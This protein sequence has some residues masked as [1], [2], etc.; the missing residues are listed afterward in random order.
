MKIAITILLALLVLCPARA[1]DNGRAF[2]YDLVQTGQAQILPAW[3][4]GMPSASPAIHA[5]ISFPIAPPSD[6]SDLAVTLCFTETTGGFLRV[7]WTGLQTS[8]ML[9]DNLFEGIAMPNQRTLLIKR[10]TLTSPGTITVQSSETTLNVSRIHFEWVDPGILSLAADAKQAGLINAT[11]TVLKDGDINGAPL[12][13]T[14]D[15]I[16]NSTVTAALNEKPERIEAGVEFVGALQ[17][18]P[19]HARLEVQISGAPVD[20]AVQLILNGALVGDIAMDIPDLNDPGYQATDGTTPAYTGWRKGVIFIP[21]EK[22]KVGD[23]QFQFA[24]KDVV[25]SATASPLALKNLLLQLKYPDPAASG[26]TGQQPQS[27]PAAAE[28]LVSGT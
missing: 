13:P 5:S 17:A 25:P 3:M 2:T 15:K 14:V 20:K 21:V 6:T 18:L 24:V 11:G 10:S 28:P 27:A 26:T 7:Y 12:M 8:E 16:Q 19:L 4:T 22:L 23:N 9:S 1:D